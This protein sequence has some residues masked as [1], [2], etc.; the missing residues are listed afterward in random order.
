MTTQEAFRAGFILKCAAR[1]VPAGFANILLGQPEVT[2]QALLGTALA[3]TYNLGVKTPLQATSSLMRKSEATGTTIA[4]AI[5]KAKQRS[6]SALTDQALQ[7]LLMAAHY[8]RA[9]KALLSPRDGQA[10]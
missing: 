2:K 7:E 6:P 3:G 5:L 4:D 8:Q 10:A 1:G 9:R